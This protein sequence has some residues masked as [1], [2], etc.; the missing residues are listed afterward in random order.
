MFASRDLPV[1]DPQVL[2]WAGFFSQLLGSGN[3]LPA[4]TKLPLRLA[5]CNP[6]ASLFQAPARLRRGSP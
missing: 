3:F 2:R 5:Q 4:S 1:L 6:P